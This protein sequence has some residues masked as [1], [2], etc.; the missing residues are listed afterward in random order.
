M[1][2]YNLKKVLCQLN[3]WCATNNISVQS[4]YDE[5]H[6]MTLQEIVYYL[7]GV[8]KEAVN[9]V[10]ENTDAFQELYNFVHNYF[11]NLDVQEEVNNKIEEMANDGTLSQIIASY[12]YFIGVVNNYNELLEYVGT[13]TTVLDTSC[14]GLYLI[15][16]T[17]TDYS[18]QLNNGKYANCINSIS[19]PIYFNNDVQKAINYSSHAKLVCDLLGKEYYASSV[20]TN[21]ITIKNGVLKSI[22]NNGQT[23]ILNVNNCSIKLI[24][25][26]LDGGFYPNTKPS[27]IPQPLL[28]VN[29]CENVILENCNIINGYEQNITTPQYMQ[30]RRSTGVT[31]IDVKN[32][33]INNCL[34]NNMYTSGSENLYILPDTLERDKI[35]VTIK[36]TRF[37][38]ITE[39]AYTILCGNLTTDNIY[40]NITSIDM[41]VNK[42]VDASIV[43]CLAINFK[44]TNSYYT[45]TNSVANVYD[46]SERTFFAGNSFYVEACTCDIDG[47]SDN[48]SATFFLVNA[49]YITIK[50]VVAKSFNR[51][52]ETVYRIPANQQTIHKD[53]IQENRAT[54]STVVFDGINIE[55]TNYGILIGGGATQGKWSIIN[56][57]FKD[58]AFQLF[59]AVETGYSQIYNINNVRINCGSLGLYNNVS[60]FGRL[61]MN[62]CVINSTAEYLFNVSRSIPYAIITGNILLG[63]NPTSVA[64]DMS[65]VICK[66]NFN[67]PDSV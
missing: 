53:Q 47:N 15:S 63:T 26:T 9:Q 55:I 22:N 33:Y 66:N 14:N 7:L 58:T 56:C 43:N 6:G 12:A 10:I 11:D 32:T 46:Q 62:N 51:L 64:N 21:D 19:S 28:M 5:C 36:N 34:F 4:V 57:D 65:N 67:I 16:D 54:P 23:T 45:A 60:G 8:V 52:F 25:I 48:N 61:F 17:S 1:S 3:Q 31:L 49:D 59:G 39:S 35:N 18:I 50:N 2:D 27:H 29:N 13:K 42:L 38:K 44:D 37:T 20:I 41:D 40:C 24:N 30:D